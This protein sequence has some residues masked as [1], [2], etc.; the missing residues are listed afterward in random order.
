MR[1]LRTFSVLLLAATIALAPAL[2]EAR[3][4]GS[5]RSG[6][7]T[8]YQSQGSR[9]SRPYTPNG[10]QSMQRSTTQPSTAASPAYGYGYAGSFWN[11]HPFLTALAGGFFGAWIGSWLFPSWGWG[12]MVGGSI[13][14]WLLIIMVVM[15]L[16]RMFRRSAFA[17]AGGPPMQG[18]YET[19]WPHGPTAIGG[20]IP[21]SAPLV[22]TQQDHAAF[23]SLLKS[24]QAAWSAGDLTALRRYVTPEMLSYFSE[25]LAN[26]TSQGVENRVEQVTLLNGDVRESWD[27]GQLQYATALLRWSALDYNVR[28]GVDPSDPGYVVEGSKEHPVEAQEMWTFARSPGGHWLLSAIQQV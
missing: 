7:G 5:A 28:A 18:F 23:E 26:N 6:G 19:G 14:S 4:G 13:L 25:A 24:I 16:V 3:A 9:G 1:L 21:A 17:P 12:G 2:A 22:I 11:R 10:G 27:E 8:V 20:G 15:F